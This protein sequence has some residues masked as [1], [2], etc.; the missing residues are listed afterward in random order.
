MYIGWLISLTKTIIFLVFPI[1]IGNNWNYDLG[2]CFDI[3]PAKKS[4]NK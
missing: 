1:A 3:R 2:K 4:R